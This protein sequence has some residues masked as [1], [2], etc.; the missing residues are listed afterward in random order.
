MS[1]HAQR[2]AKIKKPLGE[3]DSEGPEEKS[4]KQHALHLEN[5]SVVIQHAMN[6]IKQS[7]VEKALIEI[8]KTVRHWPSG[9]D[10]AEPQAFEP[11][12]SATGI[13]AEEILED[14]ATVTKVCFSYS[15]ETYDFIS[16]IENASFEDRSL[17]T[18]TLH[19]NGERVINI[20]IVQNRSNDHFNYRDLNAFKYGTWIENVVRIEEEIKQQNESPA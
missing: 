3:A 19:E 16:R 11:L 18:I 1:A 17:G 8:L 4:K 12:F 13:S 7:G 2:M 9:F 5:A 10:K 6:T 20:A 15:G 14:D